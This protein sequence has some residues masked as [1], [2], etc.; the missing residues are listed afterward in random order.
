[1]IIKWKW[2][3]TKWKIRQN[4]FFSLTDNFNDLWK[5]EDNILIFVSGPYVVNERSSFGLLETPSSTSY[6]GDVLNG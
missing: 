4:Y 1:M 5:F 3:F 6:H 2:I